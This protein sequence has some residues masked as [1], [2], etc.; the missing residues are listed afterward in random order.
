M[1]HWDRNRGWPPSEWMGPLPMGFFPVELCMSKTDAGLA[2]EMLFSAAVML[3]TGFA[4][5]LFAQLCDDDHV[6]RAIGERGG[7]PAL[8]VQVKTALGADAHGS[9]EATAHFPSEDALREHPSFWYAVLYVP[10]ITIAR[11]WLLSSADFNRLTSRTRDAR[12]GVSLRFSAPTHGGGRAGPFLV[13]PEEIGGRLART[14]RESP[15]LPPSIPDAM[16]VA[17]ATR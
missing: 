8:T 11:C 17:F 4:L 14:I 10:G 5:K 15:G 6:D 3:G 16:L 7:L 9:I 12:G 13:P 2:G 1:L